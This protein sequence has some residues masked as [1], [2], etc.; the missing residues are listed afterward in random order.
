MSQKSTEKN[1]YKYFILLFALLSYSS[2]WAQHAEDTT[3]T[4]KRKRKVTIIPLPIIYYTP[5]TRLAGG[6]LGVCLFKT[7]PKTRTSNIDL[8]TVLTS[9][10][11]RLFDIEVNMF[12][13]QEKY[14]IKSS[15]FLAKFPESFFGIGND[16]PNIPEKN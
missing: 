1:Y 3:N 4:H 9:R 2:V 13:P 12:T 16:R 8:A 5:E 15:I 7:S 6:F 10:N 14:F 11:Q